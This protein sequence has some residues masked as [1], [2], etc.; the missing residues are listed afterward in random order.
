MGLPQDTEKERRVR[1]N[2]FGA[3][4]TSPL[5]TQFNLEVFWVTLQAQASLADVC[6]CGQVQMYWFRAL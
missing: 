6:L 2:M 3:L 5:G 1:D 4:Y